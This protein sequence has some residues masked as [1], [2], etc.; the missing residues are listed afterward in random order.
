MTRLT[1]AALVCPLAMSVGSCAAQEA[2]PGGTVDVSGPR[3]RELL[4]GKLKTIPG[5]DQ[6]QIL[7]VQDEAIGRVFRGYVFYALRFRQYPVARVPPDPLQPNNLFVVKPDESV[8]H[9][10]D[11]KALQSFFRSTLP[12]VRTES[13]AKNAMKAWLRLVEE[14]QQDG[15]LQF[16]IPEESMQVALGPGG[17]YEV[18]GKAVVTPDGGNRGEIVASLTFDATGTLIS[19]SESAAI[20]RGIRPICQATKLLDADPIVRGMAEQAILV[21]G[22]AAKEYLDEQ[23]AQ[24]SPA[25]R[26]AIDRLWQRILGEQR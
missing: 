9:L 8:V 25:L 18:T 4:A 15:F 21:M 6:G 3:A 12:A 5:A 20:K 11:T 7:S 19:A 22:R 16:S 14:L 10:S 24:A 2:R 1:I 26:D 17:G 23:R 13:G